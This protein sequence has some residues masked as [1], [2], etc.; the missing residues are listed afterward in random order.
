M[1]N[2]GAKSRTLLNLGAKSR[3]CI[4]YPLYRYSPVLTFK[5]TLV[6]NKCTII[7]QELNTVILLLFYTSM[8]QYTC[9]ATIS[10]QASDFE[11]VTKQEAGYM[12]TFMSVS[13]GA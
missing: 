1:L 8:L 5:M 7:N 9:G 11:I 6:F 3:A 2:L 10:F 12:A 4:V 13:I